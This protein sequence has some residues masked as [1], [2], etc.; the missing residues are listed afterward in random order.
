MRWY[1]CAI[2]LYSTT[3]RQALESNPRVAAGV[4]QAGDAL[5]KVVTDVS[6]FAQ[7]TFRGQQQQQPAQQEQEQESTQATNPASESFK[8]GTADPKP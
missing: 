7:Q 8:L 4:K 6:G 5:H 2:V 1:D 3:I